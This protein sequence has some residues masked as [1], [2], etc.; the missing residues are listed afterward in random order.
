MAP[1]GCLLGSVGANNCS[2]GYVFLL[3]SLSPPF[4]LNFL[5]QEYLHF[6]IARRGQYLNQGIKCMVKA[7]EE[8]TL[9]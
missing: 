9:G 3:I 6:K 1:S 2:N 8:E 5:L 7:L 4:N